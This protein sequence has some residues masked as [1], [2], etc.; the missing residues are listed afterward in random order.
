[1]EPEMQPQVTEARESD[2]VVPSG[3]RPVVKRHRVAVPLA[4]P[5]VV[6]HLVEQLLLHSGLTMGEA[7]RRM[8]LVSGDALSQVKHG[9]KE[10]GAQNA[11]RPTFAW[12]V[13]FAGVCG[14]RI[15]IEYPSEPIQ[16]DPEIR[17]KRVKP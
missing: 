1:M 2:L 4:S 8:G 9:L 6:G 17:Q 13:R 14:A 16:W 5:G 15:A 3:Y 10:H 12:M 11:R 7:G